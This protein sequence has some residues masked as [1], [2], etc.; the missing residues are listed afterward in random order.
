MPDR[1]GLSSTRAGSLGVI[2]ADAFTDNGMRL[3][4]LEP[5]LKDRLKKLL[6]DYV[7]GMNLC[8]LQPG[9]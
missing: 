6:P 8:R 5:P 9:C 2:A 7:C 1:A 3:A 4:D